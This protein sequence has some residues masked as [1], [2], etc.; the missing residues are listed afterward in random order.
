MNLTYLRYELLRSFRNTRF[1]IFSLVFPVVLFLLVAG[2][3]RYEELD[4]ISFPLYYMSGMVAWGT[5]AAIMAGGARIAF[6]RSVGWNRQVRLTPLPVGQY[7]AA[8][9]VS[10]Y[11]IAAISIMLLYVAGTWMGVR[12]PLAD[13]ATMTLLVL[14]GLVPFAVGGI[15]LGHVL[16]VDTMGPAM[17]G[18]IALLALLG[19]AWGPLATHGVLRWL[20]EGLPSYWLVQ[21]GKSATTGGWWPAQAWLVLAVWTAALA[22]AAV[23]VFPRD[24]ARA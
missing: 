9:V 3:N 22:I 21:A 19:G 23:N 5:M 10:S 18:I 14:I 13:W 4:G 17:G 20:T 16:N 12:L 2:P 1:F 15:A 11:V 8:K 6:D 7:L 24:T